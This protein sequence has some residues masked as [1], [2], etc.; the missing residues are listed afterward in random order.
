MGANKF[1]SFSVSYLNKLQYEETFEKKLKKF[2]ESNSLIRSMVRVSFRE[3]DCK[4]Q[5][6]INNNFYR[7]NTLC[8]SERVT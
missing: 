7:K 4:L 5:K 6:K 3:S 2:S 8:A 1:K